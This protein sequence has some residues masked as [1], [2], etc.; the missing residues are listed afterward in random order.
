MLSVSL[1][2]QVYRLPP[3]PL[4]PQEAIY[5]YIYNIYVYGY[6]WTDMAIYIYIY[7]YISPSYA[8]KSEGPKH[9]FFNFQ[10]FPISGFLDMRKTIPDTLQDFNFLIS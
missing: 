7:I 6:I 1:L 9:F 8:D 4:T 10:C 5:I 2:D 3:L